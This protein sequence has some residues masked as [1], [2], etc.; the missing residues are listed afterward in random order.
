MA[1]SGQRTFAQ[2]LLDV[3]RDEFIEDYTV[4]LLSTTELTK[5]YHISLSSLN[6][7]ISHYELVRDSHAVKSRVNSLVKSKMFKEVIDKIS[8]EDLYRY[9]IEEDHGYY[10]TLKHFNVTDW[11]FNKLLDAYDI[12][13][14]RS[15]SFQKGLQK[16]ID[17]YGIGNETN[18]RKGH[19]TR[20]NHYGSI[21]ESYRQGLEKQKE[22]MLERYGVAR[23]WFKD[24]NN[25]S[26]RTSNVNKKFAEKLDRYG[27]SYEVEYPVY[28][29]VFDFKI[30]DI[31]VEI[32]PYITHNTTFNP[33]NKKNDY[34]GIGINYHKEKSKLA[35][36]HGYRCIHVWDWD[37]TGKIIQLLLKR[38]RIYARDC[39]VREIYLSEA[40]EFL[41]RYHLQNYGRCRIR[42]GLY[43]K[44][45]LV[46]VMTFSKPRYNKKYDYEL[47]RYAS[48]HQ[49]IG[50]AEKLFKYFINNYAPKSVISYCDNSKFDGKVYKMLG[51]I[52]K[53][54][55]IP[56]RH[57]YNGKNHYTDAF[58]R[59]IGFSQAIHGCSAKEDNLD[60]SDNTI[61]MLREG[62]YEIYDCGQA[63]HVWTNPNC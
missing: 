11:T 41:D 36:E 21:E 25:I 31:L 51:F 22:T 16:R 35:Q 54:S 38:K 12:K 15:K 8:R 13:K 50:G 28:D 32:D 49:V 17:L 48:S 40:K 37:D 63:T 42:L 30:G 59:Q 6:K 45:E 33:Y 39:Q 2:I 5:K 20:A 19:E 4:K 27:I 29:R 44:D 14:D 7:I 3:P 60:T 10:E 55:G 9:Y 47:I 46:S 53:S 18:W 24:D 56:T 1:K 52:K 43:Y 57:W 62:Y 23:L 61:L 58:I 34:I 26:K